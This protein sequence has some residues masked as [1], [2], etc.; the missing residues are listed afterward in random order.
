MGPESDAEGIILTLAAIAPSIITSSELLMCLRNVYLQ[1]H[2]LKKIRK[3]RM[4]RTN[5]GDWIIR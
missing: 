3:K 2:S 1:S 4:V 5:T